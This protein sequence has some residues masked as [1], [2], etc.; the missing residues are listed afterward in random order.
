MALDLAMVEAASTEQSSDVGFLSHFRKLYFFSLPSKLPSIF[1]VGASDGW[2]P[3]RVQ[4]FILPI[5][6]SG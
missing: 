1:S 3:G 2:F 5:S 6:F 4:K